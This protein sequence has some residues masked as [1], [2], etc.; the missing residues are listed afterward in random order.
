[1]SL[2]SPLQVR[3]SL[4]DTND[5]APVITPFSLPIT[6]SEDTPIDSIV[7]VVTAT[8]EDEGTNA[9]I[10]YVII[11]GNVGGV[12]GTRSDGSIRIELPLD[13][14]TVPIYS[15][16]IEARDGGD[17]PMID[18]ITVIVNVTDVNDNAPQFVEVRLSGPIP[19]VSLVF[20]SYYISRNFLSSFVLSESGKSGDCH[21][22]H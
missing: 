11:S 17:P 5:H 15:L 14:E 13:H 18:S 6:I 16:D 10:E 21:G 7:A 2:L 12:F 9:E 1:M 4:L 20:S 19:E 3:V 8:D 22:N